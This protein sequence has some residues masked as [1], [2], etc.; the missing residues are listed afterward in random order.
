[1]TRAGAVNSA[2]QQVPAQ[3]AQVN[4]TVK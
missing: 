3:T 2:Q 4:L 1:M